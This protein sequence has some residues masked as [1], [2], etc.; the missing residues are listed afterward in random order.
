MVFGC[1]P[2]TSKAIHHVS[3]QT[4]EILSNINV[5]IKRGRR[6]FYWHQLDLFSPYYN[7]NHK[8]I[9]HSNEFWIMGSFG[10]QPQRRGNINDILYTHT[11]TLQSPIINILTS[12]SNQN[13]YE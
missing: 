3:S 10:K 12:S 4:L 7:P 13:R 5:V 9:Q 11:Q 6:G 1:Q 8:K 2:Q